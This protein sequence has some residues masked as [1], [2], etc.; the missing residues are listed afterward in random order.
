MKIRLTICYSPAPRTVIEKTLELAAPCTVRGAIES[1]GLHSDPAFV[2]DFAA[3]RLATGI[4]GEQVDASHLLK[5]QDRI[6]IYRPLAV[7]PKLARRRR[8]ERQ[9]ARATGLFAKR[10]PGSKQGY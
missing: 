9:G 1:S 8:F 3:G 7:D 10:R 6:E 2:A 4:W 5:D